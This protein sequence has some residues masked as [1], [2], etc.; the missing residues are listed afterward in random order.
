MNRRQLINNQMKKWRIR[1]LALLTIWILAAL[2]VSTLK[3]DPTETAFV[4]VPIFIV[5]ASQPIMGL[6]RGVIFCPDCGKQLNH[7]LLKNMTSN[8]T[9]K[10]PNSVKSCPECNVNFDD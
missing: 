9:G 5:F 1:S 3:L 6:C 8:W 2:T 10:I 4:L 7:I